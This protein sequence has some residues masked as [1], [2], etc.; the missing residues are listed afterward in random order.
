M[1]SSKKDL[2]ISI[3]NYNTGEYLLNCLESIGQV[4]NEANIQVFVIDNASAD[5]SFEKAKEEFPDFKFIKNKE[6]LGFSKAHNIALEKLDSEYIL[7]L[8]PDTKLQKGVISKMLDFMDKNI[9]V[10]AATCEI[11]LPN[12][13]ID[14]TAHRG[15]PT[16][17]ASFL[18]FLGDAS[19]YHLTNRNL[20]QSHEV[21][22]ISGSF[23]LTRKS[24]L[25][26]IGLFDE[27]YF[28]YAEDIDLCYRIKQAGYKIMYVPT[29][30][31]IH[32]KGVSS[33]LKKHSQTMT[34]ATEETRKKSLDAFYQT[35]K[36]FYK[37]HYE[38]QY[39]T[40]INWLVYLGI[41]LKW[42]LAKRKLT[43]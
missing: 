37:K 27:D 4:N 7:I 38:K 32:Y 39:P 21:D 22:A 17:L 42:W 11:L 36:I 34:T 10:G 18:Y 24:V 26:K 28:M 29:V 41:S 2:D 9:D 35:M 5:G 23:F 14:L 8:N 43:V 16:P 3:V 33:G 15:F 20:D 12:G 19:L 31:I 25:D 40:I 13:K 6:N 1:K 30:S